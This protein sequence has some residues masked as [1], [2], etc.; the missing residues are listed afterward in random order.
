M[1]RVERILPER[2]T[3]AWGDG[4]FGASRGDRTH[5][6]IDYESIPGDVVLSPCK[7]Q[8]TKLGYPYAVKASDP[9]TYRYVEVTDYKGYKHRCFYVEPSIGLG[10]HI[11]MHTVIG[12]AQDI[13]GKYSTED[14]VMKNHV[15]Y[16][17]L[18]PDGNPVNPMEYV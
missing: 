14:R 15:H 9:I 3:D 10:L 17:I 5:K 12:V 2:G 7:G 6:G 4:S 1:I 8:V 16:E 13:A 18:D 11:D